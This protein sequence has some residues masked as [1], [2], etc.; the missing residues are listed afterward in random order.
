MHV[1]AAVG[2]WGDHVISTHMTM[3]FKAVL[4]LNNTYAYLC[5]WNTPRR[6]KVI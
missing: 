4:T 1:E 2:M 3:C 5:L 6:V